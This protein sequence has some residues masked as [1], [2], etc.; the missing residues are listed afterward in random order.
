MAP[1]GP[2]D[3]LRGLVTSL[4]SSHPKAGEIDEVSNWDLIRIDSLHHF[5]QVTRVDLAIGIEDS[6]YE[7]H[8]LL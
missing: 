1:E 8:L 5:Q 2:G 7:F 6:V 4:R 3:Y